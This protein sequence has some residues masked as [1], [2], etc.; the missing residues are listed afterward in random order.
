MHKEL[1]AR[2]RELR[3]LRNHAEHE[4]ER[5]VPEKEIRATF[6][7]FLGIGVSGV[8]PRLLEVDLR[9]R[10]ARRRSGGWTGQGTSG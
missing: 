1:P 6:A 10:I 2:L 4:S 7:R 3:R 9:E 8:L 5:G